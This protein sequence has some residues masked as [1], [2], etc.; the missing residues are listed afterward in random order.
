MYLSKTGT[1]TTASRATFRLAVAGPCDTQRNQAY[2][3]SAIAKATGK[4]G[5]GEICRGYAP[6]EDSTAFLLYLVTKERQIRRETVVA[7][8]FTSRLGKNLM[9]VGSLCADRDVRAFKR[10]RGGLSI[11]R[12]LLSKMEEHGARNGATHSSLMSLSYV[13][14]YYYR[15]GYR[16][17]TARVSDKVASMGRY[18]TDRDC[19]L[20]AWIGAC[21]TGAMEMY[22][23]EWTRHRLIRR[24]K[25]RFPDVIDVNYD[26]TSM[27]VIGDDWINLLDPRECK[28]AFSVLNN[29]RRKSP[30]KA[31]RGGSKRRGWKYTDD[32]GEWALS[33]EYE[34]FKMMKKL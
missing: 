6:D 23:S 4:L 10:I 25:E 7:C 28:V 3:R 20:S 11:G 13:I 8:G 22:E 26:G 5:K 9:E 17:S 18:S 14:P 12:I 34:G 1:L 15:N 19:I 29:A 27:I 30:S 24:V 21:L 33:G 16:F 31:V 2:A 32:D